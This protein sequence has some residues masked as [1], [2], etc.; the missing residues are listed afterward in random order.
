MRLFLAAVVAVLLA[1]L[2]VPVGAQ[3]QTTDEEARKAAQ[4]IQAAR[5]RANAAAEAFFAAQSDLEALEDRSVALAREADALEE[6]VEKLRGDV[7]SLAV[8]R[9]ASSG[10]AGIPLLTGLQPPKDQVQAQVL[11]GVVSN[12]GTS[13]L[14]EYDVLQKE[15]ADKRLEVRAHRRDVEAQQEVFTQLQEAAEAEVV[16]LREIEE[17]R[18][19]DIAVRRALE[20]QQAAARSEFEE[21]ILRNAEAASRAQP[22]PGV[23]AA[24][25]AAAELA[26]AVAAGDAGDADANEGDLPTAGA[27]VPT[28]APNTGASGGTSGGRT[29]TGGAGSA[30][31]GVL[32][33]ESYLDAI[34][35]PLLGSAYGD[36]WGAPRS[37]GRRHEGVDMLALAG[38]PLYAAA[39]G[40]VNFKQN[41]LGGNAVSLT[42]DNGNRY[43]YAHLSRYEGTNRRV[44]QGEVIGYVGDTGNATGI[45]HLHFEIH[46]GGGLAVN[47]TPS[48]RL[49]G[50]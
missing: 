5:D 38:T 17:Q 26:A 12:A 24:E 48:I 40:V 46:P 29:G 20:A 49:A 6:R 47:P 25:A 14:D 16:Q 43:Y 11:G 33:G 37:G 2:L 44:A 34:A 10:S 23:A 28:I 7:Q 42:A 3:A 8:A 45:P 36:S 18:L 32:N 22:N 9:F 30:P 31:I 4:E 15:L 21:A 35:C 50:C 39:S 1:G 13:A 19:T 27:P 41:T